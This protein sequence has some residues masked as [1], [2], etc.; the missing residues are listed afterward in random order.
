[1]T[2]P[3][4]SG[5]SHHQP[6]QSPSDPAQT[7]YDPP[8]EAFHTSTTPSHGSTIWRGQEAKNNAWGNSAPRQHYQ[9][10]PLQ[11]PWGGQSAGNQPQQQAVQ[12]QPLQSQP[13][14]QQPFQQHMWAAPA[15][16]HYPSYQQAPQ[17]QYYQQQ[18]HQ[19][20]FQQQPW[21]GQ[22]QYYGGAPQPPQQQYPWSGAPASALPAPQ[23]AAKGALWPALTNGALLLASLLFGFFKVWQIEANAMGMLAF[24]SSMNWWGRYH[25]SGE[26]LGEYAQQLETAAGSSTRVAAGTFVV[27]VLYGLAAYFAAMLRMKPSAFLGLGAAG[28]QI[29]MIAITAGAV[30]RGAVNEVV[31]DAVAVSLGTGWYV[32]LVTAIA[33]FAASLILLL[34]A[35]SQEQPGLPAGVAMARLSQPQTQGYPQ[36]PEG[37]GQ[38]RPPY[39]TYGI[40][41][42]PGTPDSGQPN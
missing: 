25:I 29:I 13:L 27:L 28:L 17:Q 21:G 16:Q 6:S 34:R 22:Q 18:P 12:H 14:Q 8:T 15:Q 35:R 31:T 11:Q 7:P 4:S 5:P 41:S 19:V 24:Q 10:Q 39:G 2:T 32:W 20:P 33:G 37:F 40:Y 36:Q 38:Q 23:S 26:G 9:Q 3:H 1:M 42:Q 30:P